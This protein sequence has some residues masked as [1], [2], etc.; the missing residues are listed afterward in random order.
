MEMSSEQVVRELLKA[1]RHDYECV[2]AEQEALNESLQEALQ[3]QD[4]KWQA[5]I[6]GDLRQ[7]YERMLKLQRRIIDLSAP[8][9]Y[10]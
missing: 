4:I 10:M 7:V 1:A 6:G 3:E 5:E 2:L 8:E 9:H